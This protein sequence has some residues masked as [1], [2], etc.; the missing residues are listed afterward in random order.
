MNILSSSRLLFV[1]GFL[2]LAATNIAI[3][4]GIVSNRTGNPDTLITLAE[5]ELR[6]PYSINEEN[7]GLSLRLVWRALG[8][9]GNSIYGY[10]GWRSPA[11][12]SAEKLDELGFKIDEYLGS[13]NNGA[14]YKTPL[15][16]EVF[17]VLENNG[18]S[19]LEAVRRS[20]KVLEREAGLFKLKR[21]DKTLRDNYEKAEKQLKRER[22]ESSRLFAIDAG[23]DPFELRKKY[24]N[25]G[26][27]I[28]VKGLVKPSYL[29][30]KKK[31]EVFG[32]ISQISTE[33]IHV[34][35]KHRKVLDDILAQDKQKHH[36]FQQSRYEIELAYGSRLEP[37]VMSVKNLADKS[38]NLNHNLKW[39][40]D[41]N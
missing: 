37:W 41:D 38:E 4:I 16:K 8:R 28:I 9:G 21:E 6:L 12:F 26:Q 24:D 2:L 35:L 15:P 13:A 14:Y 27:Y 10:S 19:Y 29:R 31:K 36:E 30:K 25:R 32:I 33:N 7:T 39:P 1:L 34:P 40:E 17:I 18:E 5:R 3:F 20:E 23:L 22:T 11:W